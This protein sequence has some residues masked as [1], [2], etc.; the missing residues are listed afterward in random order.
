LFKLQI[1][2]V[3]KYREPEY[4]PHRYMKDRIWLGLIGAIILAALAL[5]EWIVKK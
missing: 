1:Y 4:D 2:L 3:K 5:V